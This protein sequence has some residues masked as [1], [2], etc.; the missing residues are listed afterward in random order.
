MQLS[1]IRNEA[2]QIIPGKRRKSDLLHDRSRLTDGIKLAHQRMG[3]IDLVV[4]IGADH[5]QV[6]HVRLGQQVGEHV[7]RRRVEPLQ[8]VEEQ[9]QRMVG[10]R[11]HTDE[12]PKHQLETPLCLPRWKLRDRRLLSDEELQFGDDID[13]QP[14]VRA[15]RLAEC[16]APAGQL[17]LALAEQRA[18]Q[19]LK[20][21]RQGGIGDVALVL[22][23]LA[24]GEE[25]ARRHQRLVQL[26]DDGR[27]ADAGI[28]R[29]QHQLRPAAPDHAVEGSEQ[30]LDLALAPVQFL[31]NH[32]PVG[33]I[34]L[35]EREGVDPVLRLPC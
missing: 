24:R 9:R 32:K 12:P 7:E 1:V 8:I 27:L 18:D 5:Q 4:A 19:A 33:R 3:G 35:A 22:V 29:D 17:G 28:A 15:Q 14:S 31:G 30:A 6:P 23:E 20:R 34:L 21:L 13:H 26:V 16:I 25:P 11:E 10:P 2:P